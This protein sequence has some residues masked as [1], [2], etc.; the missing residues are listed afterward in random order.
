V[1][2]L[3]RDAARRAPRRGGIDF[4]IHDWLDRYL[5]EVIVVGITVACLILIAVAIQEMHSEDLAW[6]KYAASHHCEAKGT[7]KGEVEPVIGGKGGVTIG[8]DQAIYV[9]DG[10]E[11]VIR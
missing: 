5:E 9:C 10:G 6:Q 1:Y 3:R 4:V 2:E 7:K 11:I 8:Q